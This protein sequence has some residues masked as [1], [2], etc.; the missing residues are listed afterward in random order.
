MRKFTTK[1]A[2]V[3]EPTPPDQ[4]AYSEE[5]LLYA[6]S[7]ADSRCSTY[8]K[9]NLTLYYHPMY[10]LI[11]DDWRQKVQNYDPQ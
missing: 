6:R 5:Q 1:I 2:T 11:D 3:G 4:Y 10:P 7:L 9:Q 8:D